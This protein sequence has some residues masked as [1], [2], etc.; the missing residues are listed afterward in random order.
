MQPSIANP[1]LAEPGVPDA[2]FALEFALSVHEIQQLGFLRLKMAAVVW[3]A[4]HDEP[5]DFAYARQ[6]AFMRWMFVTGRLSDGVT[7]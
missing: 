7:A 1:N 3:Q 2:W 6:L 4:D 5:V